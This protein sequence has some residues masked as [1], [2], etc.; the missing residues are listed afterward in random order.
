MKISHHPDISTLLTCSAGATPEALCAVVASHLSMCT[1]CRGEIGQMEDIGVSLFENLPPVALHD[2][3]RPEAMAAACEVVNASK[4]SL[5][6]AS[7]DIPSPL[8]C[9]LGDQLD[10]INWQPSGT[11]GVQQYRIELSSA[12]T[13]DLRLLKLDP[14]AQ[15]PPHGHGC[16]ELT[17]V[18]RG[19]Y[20]DETGTYG[21]GD[22][23][24]IDDGQTHAPKADAQ[25]GCILLTASEEKPAYIPN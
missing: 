8:I 9:V 23:C 15:I 19:A 25:L 18:L 10:Q 13:G 6:P 14:G 5:W 20:S 17:I 3:T 12:A 16:E 11:P 7:G 22:F 2:R 24:E 1:Q 4:G 21:A